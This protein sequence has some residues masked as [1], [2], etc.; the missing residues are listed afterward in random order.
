[1]TKSE[2]KTL[3]NFYI[4][5]E[6]KM[7]KDFNDL[8]N[9][10][11]EKN[12][13]TNFRTSFAVFFILS[14]LVLLPSLLND[15]NV[16]LFEGTM[17]ISIFS[18]IVSIVLSGI[19]SGIEHIFSAKY[20]N[21]EYSFL[22][23]LKKEPKMDLLKKIKNIRK[24]I[25]LSDN[26]FL[27]IKTFNSFGFK[28]N[29]KYSQY[30][31]DCSYY[32]EQNDILGDILRVYKKNNK[33]TY[34]SDLADILLENDGIDSNAKSLVLKRLKEGHLDEKSKLEEKRIIAELSTSVKKEDILSVI[35]E[36]IKNNK[37]KTS[38]VL[39]L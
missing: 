31:K 17:I 34:L 12:K 22:K 19:Y 30:V 21:G 29:Y 33:E 27:K 28:N 14:S 3:I 6:N 8:K 20:T 1:M 25:K 9:E 4:K 16:N 11:K 36:K 10:Y 7:L 39:A 32:S 24:I 35:D 2:F 37:K 38:I 13:L 26:P 5:Y 15:N 23:I 18:L